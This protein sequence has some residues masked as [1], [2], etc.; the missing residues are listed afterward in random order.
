[1]SSKYVF[2]PP[3]LSLWTIVAVKK[4][5]SICKFKTLS[6][7]V[8]PINHTERILK[9]KKKAHMLRFYGHEQN[10]F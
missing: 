8:Y 6:F 1:M 4:A 3:Y 9:L 5:V 10:A 7:H 2:L